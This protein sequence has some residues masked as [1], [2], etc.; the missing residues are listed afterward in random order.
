MNPFINQISTKEIL[1]LLSSM[2][3]DSS[4]AWDPEFSV[5][6]I[7]NA[8]LLQL[9][10]QKLELILDDPKMIIPTINTMKG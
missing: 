4:A 7:K 3:I 1:A 10:L 2:E 5:D 6:V 9:E 8:K